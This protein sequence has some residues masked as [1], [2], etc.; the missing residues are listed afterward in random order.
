[1]TLT[2]PE[3]I[4]LLGPSTWEEI[5][6]HQTDYPQEFTP[7][8]LTCTFPP[9]SFF[10]F[11]IPK[12]HFSVH[13]VSQYLYSSLDGPQTHFCVKWPAHGARSAMSATPMNAGW[14]PSTGCFTAK[15]FMDLLQCDWL[16]VIWVRLMF[17]HP[18]PSWAGRSYC[19]SPSAQGTQQI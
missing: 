5:E 2:Y 18:Q 16:S 19:N 7:P 9:H 12:P 4:R 13:F 11:L 6:S 17:H 3:N 15:R 8:P 1:M 14:P 10:S